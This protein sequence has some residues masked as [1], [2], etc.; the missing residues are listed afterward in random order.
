MRHTPALA[1]AITI[2]LTLAPTAL[3]Q[4]APTVTEAPLRAHLAFLAD[5]L[6]EGRGTGQHGGALTVRYLE[7]QSAAI[8]LKPAN[9]ASY[10][11]AVAMIGA[12][13]LTSSAITFQLNGQTLA[14]ALGKDI[15]YGTGRADA[16][17]R[18]DASVVFVGYGISAP[19]EQWDDYKGMDVKGKLLIVMVND[20]KPT[21]AEPNRFGGKSL[22]YN[23]RWVYKYEEAVRRGAAGV[24]AWTARSCEPG[25]C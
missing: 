21:A 8:G 16:K 25:S 19:D 4:K 2:G 1:I 5:D 6:L 7:T 24:V 14:P 11:Q 13:T 15:V 23:G 3:A 10:R 22:T 20:P 17:V 18:F 9:G 12:Q